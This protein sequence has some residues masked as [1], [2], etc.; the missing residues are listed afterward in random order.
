MLMAMQGV[1][2]QRKAWQC[3][4]MQGVAGQRTEWRGAAVHGRAMRGKDGRALVPC[5]IFRMMAWKSEH[6]KWR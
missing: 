5:F 4:A 1:A 3:V 2:G 6:T